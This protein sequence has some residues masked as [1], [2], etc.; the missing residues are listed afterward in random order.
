MD[1][2]RI[3]DAFCESKRVDREKVM[4]TDR[5]A[6]IWY[7][8]YMIWMYMHRELK[9]SA[10]KLSDIFKRNRPS[11]FRGIRI[12]EHQLMY[13]KDLREQYDSAVGKLRGVA[14]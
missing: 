4:G 13:H 5:R 11:I 8:R 1:V 14:D 6:E 3:I 7:T 2:D 12:L 9:V 10:S